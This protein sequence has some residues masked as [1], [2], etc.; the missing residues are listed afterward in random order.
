MLRVYCI[1]SIM[2][3]LLFHSCNPKNEGKN[4]TIAF[5]QCTGNDSWR[6]TMLEEMKRELSFYPNVKFIYRDAEGS[7]Q[8]Q[9]SQIRELLKN[10]IDLLIV[11]PNEAAPVTPIVD[12]VFQMKIPVI[13][14]DR[15]TSSGLYNAY[16]GADNLTIGKLA[17]QYISNVL[18][19]KGQ[20]GVITGLK[21][22]SASI[23]RK[24]GLMMGLDSAGKTQV[25]LEL[26]SDWSRATAYA[27]AKKQ[28]EDLQKQDLIFAFNDQM[29]FGAIQAL[30]ENGNDK[31][32]I[33]GIDALPGAK[34]GL[35]EIAN[36]TLYASMLYPT[37]GT[38]AIRTAIAILEK[39]PYKRENILGTLVINKENAN[40]MMLQSNKIQEQQKDIDKR[41]EFIVKQNQIYNN[42]KTT[43]QVVMT[44]LVISIILGGISIVM[45]GNNRKK[46][47]QLKNQNEEILQQ[48]QQIVEM[49]QQIQNGAEEQSKFFTNVSHEFKTPLTLIMGPLEELEKEKSLSA[50]SREKLAYIERNAKK[51]QDL[52]HDLID[53]HR[54]DKS[55][56]KLQVTAV[57]ID[58]FIQQIIAN[59]RPLAKKKG[60]SLSYLSKTPLK[61]IW[62]SEQL[63]EHAFSNLLSNAFKYTP[64][65]GTISLTVEE[66]TFGDY[67]LIRVIDNG[68]GIAASDLDHIFDNFYKGEQHLPGSGIG[69]AYVKQIVE[70]HHGQVT[71][72][73]KKG[74][75]S[76]FTLRLPTGHLHLLEEEKKNSQYE[77]SILHFERNLPQEN[78]E[79]FDVD[80]V[81]FCSSRAANILIVEDHPDI[82]RFLKEILEKEYNLIFAK[83]YSDALKKM[84]NNYPDLILSDIMLPDETGI[85]L[86]KTVKNNSQFNQIPVLLLSALDTEESIIEGMRHMADAYL[87]KPFKVDHLKA[88]VAN[89][90]LSRQKLKEQ[91][92][93][94]LKPSGNKTEIDSHTPQDKH[95]LQGLSMVVEGHLSDKT[96]SV[97]DIAK[98]LNLSRIQ[99]YRKT[100]ALLNCSV[101]DY[102]LQRRMA[103]AQNLLLQGL[104]VNEI[105]EKVGFSSGTYFTAAF[106]KQFGVTP[107]V[108]RKDQLKG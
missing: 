102:L 106:R 35:E 92:G 46:N 50:N 17:G 52:V 86:L 11:S 3:S 31:K 48:Q 97:E 72:S 96:L 41:Q 13:V 59:F 42:Q 24:K 53:I 49:N 71:A 103:K 84:K 94:L 64:R 12:S 33:I 54:I 30:R 70:L 20:I 75:G 78:L 14:T 93:S 69:L 90:I 62:I 45:I 55:K 28:I 98:E 15:K 57:H 47:K 60:I 22:T 82:M 25:G 51:L 66:N 7:N 5:S 76:A 100:K 29:A 87:T 68:S 91:Y 23:E 73:S 19:G 36:G 67:F 44:S 16:V 26:H 101:N 1:L 6:E 88:V 2:I 105:A 18:N 95:F 85:E 37:G 80:S 4:Y 65:G 74:M 77:P 32:K 61:E 8:V 38:E 104:H 39:T 56:L 63:M 9:I 81:S 107:T 10:D 58:N 43:L 34:N 79:D 89:L 27:L 99:L 21:G 108:F 83:S 40:L